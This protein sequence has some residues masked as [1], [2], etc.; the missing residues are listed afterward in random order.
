MTAAT[1]IEAAPLHHEF[2]ETRDSVRDPPRFILR[3]M[4]A[5]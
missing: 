4:L 3:Q 5:R 1:L 2:G